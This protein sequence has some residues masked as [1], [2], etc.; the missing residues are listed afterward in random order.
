M[1]PRRH[2]RR[3]NLQ[4]R[5]SFLLFL[6]CDYSSLFC[7]LVDFSSPQVRCDWRLLQSRWQKER[8]GPSFFIIGPGTCIG[9]VW[10]VSA[11]RKREKRATTRWRRG[12][13][14]T[15][16]TRLCRAPGR[17]FAFFSETA[18]EV[19][20]E[21]FDEF[22]AKSTSSRINSRGNIHSKKMVL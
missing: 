9:P 3:Y 22:S 7:P 13:F 15:D 10:T 21:Q 2:T 19:A 17:R 11:E 18:R 1:S 20:G 14:L 4:A 16:Q 8:W 6:Q 12:L 5:L